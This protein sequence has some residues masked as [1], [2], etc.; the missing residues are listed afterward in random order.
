MRNDS[1]IYIGWGLA[2]TLIFLSVLFDQRGV[3]MNEE[4]PESPTEFAA[5]DDGDVPF[6][7]VV[8][9]TKLFPNEKEKKYEK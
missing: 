1:Y 7:G 8:M 3:E 2:W 5:V 6:Q 9:W 4:P